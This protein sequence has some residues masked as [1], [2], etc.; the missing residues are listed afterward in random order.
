METAKEVMKQLT[1]AQLQAASWT[2]GALMLLAG[3]GSGKTRVLTARIANLFES[4]P[5]GKWRILALTFTTR[6]ADEMRHRIEALIPDIANRVFT[7]TFH[8]FAVEILRQS[9]SHVG[10]KTNFQIYTALRDR[11]RL[12]S[13]ALS[14][15]KI[16][17]PESPDRALPVIDGLR[18]RLSTPDTCLRFFSDPQRGERFAA[19]FRAYEEYLQKENALDFPAILC[20]AHEL[21]TKYPAI[22]ERYRRTYRYT[23]IDEFQD[24]NAA[25]YAFVKAFSGE[26][27]KNVFIVADDDQIIYQWNGASPKR[28]QQFAEDYD[29]A[30][31]QMPTNFRCPSEVIVMANNLVAHNLLR[32]PD[33]NP[34]L[35]IKQLPP[36]EDRVRLLK[37]GTDLDEAAGVASD[38]AEHHR[39]DLGAV[40]II[41][42]TKRILTMVSECLSE[43]GIPAQIAQRR[44]SFASVP[45]Q[46]LHS[47]LKIA[48]RR[49]DSKEFSNFVEAGNVLLGA[50]MDAS[51]L[52]EIAAAGHGDLLRTWLSTVRAPGPFAEAVI[53]AVGTDLALQNDYSK[54]LREVIKLFADP[55]WDLSASHAS[56]EEDA[57]AWRDLFQDIQGTIGRQAP[58]DQ[59]LQELELRSKEPPLKP[60]VVPLLTVHG[61]KGNEFPHVY[62]MGLAEDILPSFQSKRLGDN[63]PQMEE[64][65]RNCF[66]AITRC[67]ETLTLSYAGAYT[68]WKKDPSRFLSEMRVA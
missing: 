46:W 20:R 26:N 9:G 23:T 7:G 5:K 39:D 45:F 24:T 62:V 65:R 30:V 36:K 67:G 31:V 25:Q 29:P 68:G 38:L 17:F 60:G 16:D 57:R 48:N 4:D 19:A 8:S 32:T 35:S 50:D 6:A 33:K 28:L 61:S 15:A 59:F 49:S 2:E 34:L 43:L 58:L 52:T 66:V 10:I 53:N 54:Y 41:A 11:T 27:Y 55:T 51:E 1:S 12:L 18:D 63:S 64:E 14:A 40:A 21:F 22:T 3:P 37:F 44:D 56:L 42:R 13:E 47:S